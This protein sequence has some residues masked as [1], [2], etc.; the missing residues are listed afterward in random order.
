MV[1][2]YNDE[3]AL[4]FTFQLKNKSVLKIALY[5]TAYSVV[6]LDCKPFNKL[7]M[8]AENNIGPKTEPCEPHALIF[9][10]VRTD[11]LEH[12][13]ITF[14]PICFNLYISLSCHTL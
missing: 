1:W 11:H 8:E 9:S 13:T 3:Y 14:M 6:G 4:E 7:F 10:M 12:N 5:C 2:Q